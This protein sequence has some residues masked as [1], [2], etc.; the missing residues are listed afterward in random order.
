MNQR[1]GSLMGRCDI[2][3][4][5]VTVDP[6]CISHTLHTGMV[7]MYLQFLVQCPLA[8]NASA[9]ETFHV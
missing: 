6:L 1:E 3:G 8:S 2:F 5:V 7:V 9:V 4:I